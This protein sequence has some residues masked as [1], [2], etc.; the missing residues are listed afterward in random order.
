M[1]WVTIEEFPSYEINTE[2][3]IRNI[4]TKRV[5]TP[6]KW[7]GYHVVYLYSSKGEK[8]ISVHKAMMLTFFKG[9]YEKGLVCDH[10]NGI[11]TDNRLENLEPVTQRENLHRGKVQSRE[12]VNI[13]W[14]PKKKRFKVRIKVGKV[15]RCFGGA[16]TIEEAIVKRNKALIE[17]G[18]PL[19]S[20]V[21][22]SSTVV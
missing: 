21:K 17:L 18:F 3:V 9:A 12:H 2:G 4:K 14:D 13:Y 20:Y 19:P 5:K 15:L 6:G 22:N 1:N 8:R 16:R 11:K 7:L 10:K